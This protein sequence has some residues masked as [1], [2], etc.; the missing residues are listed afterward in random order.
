MITITRET[1][2]GKPLDKDCPNLAVSFRRDGKDDPR[3]LCKGIRNEES[4]EI[5]PKCKE[6]KAYI[7]T[8]EPWEKDPMEKIR[9]EWL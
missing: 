1:L 9:R 2:R 7:E 3:I 5:L 6:C 8:A 4:G